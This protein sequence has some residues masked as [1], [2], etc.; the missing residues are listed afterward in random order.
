MFEEIERSVEIT[1]GQGRLV[2]NIDRLEIVREYLEDSEE[3]SYFDKTN[4]T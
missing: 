2:K 3:V 1:I 4:L